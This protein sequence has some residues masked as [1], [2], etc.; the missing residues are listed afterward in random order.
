M[1]SLLLA[2]EVKNAKN[3]WLS[4]HRSAAGGKLQKV[5]E[6]LKEKEKQVCRS[7]TPGGHCWRPSCPAQVSAL[8]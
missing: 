8:C 1:R 4:A 6:D 3:N 5:Y 2:A 7:S